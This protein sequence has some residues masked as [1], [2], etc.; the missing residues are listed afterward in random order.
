MAQINAKPLIGP[1]VD[2]AGPTRLFGYTVV[3]R[4]GE[5]AGSVI[6]AVTDPN[7]GQRYAL[8]HVVRT[9]DKSIRFVEQLQNEYEVGR[10]IGHPVI[11]KSIDL[12]IQ[13]SLLWKT[14]EAALVME[15]VDGV[16]MD[17]QLPDLP[18]MIEVFAQVAEGLGEMHKAELVHC[19][20]KPANVLVCKGNKA[21]LIDLGQ[22][23][24]VGTQKLRI[25][26]TPD[27]ISPEQVKCKPVTF[28]TDMFNLGAT[29]YWCLTGRKLPT[30]FNIGKGENNLLSDAL[31]PAP[32]TL[33][34]QI[35]EPLS[36]LI[37]E[38][39]RINP[40]KRPADMTELTRRLE[41]MH[42]VTLKAAGRLS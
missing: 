16:P 23:C 11:R 27:F 13:R 17:V 8:K 2:V 10:R 42:H 6:Y 15:L 28:A 25:Q 41:I 26:G 3:D 38:C 40:A 29:M 34:A 18:E 9:T 7:T 14:T 35:P 20:L 30:L 36:N 19:D 37:M 22:A 1:P 12:K 21:K 33:N 39:V 24:P 4:L 5:G 32:K 31:I